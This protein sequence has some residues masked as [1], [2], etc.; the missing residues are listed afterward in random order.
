M[1]NTNNGLQKPQAWLLG[2]WFANLRNCESL[3]CISSVC[4]VLHL[5]AAGFRLYTE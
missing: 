2:V 3:A 5:H 1:L 4:M